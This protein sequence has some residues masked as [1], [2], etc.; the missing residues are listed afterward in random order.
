MIYQVLHVGWWY[1]YGEWH[2]TRLVSIL[3]N[4][5]LSYMMEVFPPH[6]VKSTHPI[7][8]YRHD[9]TEILLKVALNTLNPNPPYMFQA[10]FL[11]Y[12][13][14]NLTVFLTLYRCFFFFFFFRYRT[15]VVANCFKFCLCYTCQAHTDVVP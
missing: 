8:S 2:S 10:R 5:Q 4:Q 9:I 7:F 14:N 13:T 15:G 11:K 6:I 12:Y 1:K 3:C